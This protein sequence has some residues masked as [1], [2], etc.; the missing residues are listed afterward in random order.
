VPSVRK[1]ITAVESRLRTSTVFGLVENFTVSTVL[2]TSVAC[3]LRR[4]VRQQ[5]GHPAA[6]WIG[7]SKNAGSGSGAYA[8]RTDANGGSRLLICER[9]KRAHEPSS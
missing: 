1:K 5:P 9:P 4:T 2:L 3:L 8:G 6:R 7:G